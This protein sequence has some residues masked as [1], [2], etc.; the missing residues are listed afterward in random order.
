MIGLAGCATS[1]GNPKLQVAVPSCDAPEFRP[2][3]PPAPIGTNDGRDLAAEYAIWGKQ[4]VI[5][6]QKRAKCE[7]EVRARFAKGG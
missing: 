3:P 4:N 5:R 2:L 1:P 6:M 7:A